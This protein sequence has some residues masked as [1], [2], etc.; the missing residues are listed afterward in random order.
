MIRTWRVAS[1]EADLGASVNSRL[2]TERLA[3]RPW[4]VEDAEAAAAVYG[5]REIARWLSPALGQVP[6][7]ESM[8]LVLEQWITE[9]ARMVPPRGRWAIER[10]D[11]QVLIG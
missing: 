8:R 6:D 5:D 7:A 3:L 11:D 2:T 1:A 9:D 10:L 4:R